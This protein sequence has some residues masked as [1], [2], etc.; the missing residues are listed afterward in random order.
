MS[1][2]TKKKIEKKVHYAADAFCVNLLPTICADTAGI[3]QPQANYKTF[4]EHL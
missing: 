4:V 2:K 1:T 3:F